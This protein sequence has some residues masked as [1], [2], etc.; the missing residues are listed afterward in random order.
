MGS[1]APS[2]L[3]PRVRIPS[4]HYLCSV[5]NLIDAPIALQPLMTS[6]FASSSLSL[7]ISPL[8]VQILF[9]KCRNENWATDTKFVYVK[10]S[11]TK[12]AVT[13]ID[14]VAEILALK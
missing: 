2:I 12:A 9:S 4:A 7:P 10:T 14:A 1:F 13:E 3:Q 5:W 6:S 8:C 11:S